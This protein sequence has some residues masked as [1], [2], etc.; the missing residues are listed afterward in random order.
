[1]DKKNRKTDG[2]DTST[3]EN[4]PKVFSILIEALKLETLTIPGRVNVAGLFLLAFIIVMYFLTNSFVSV[5]RVVATFWNGAMTE[6]TEDNILSLLIVFVVSAALCIIML[7][8]THRENKSLYRRE[9][10][11]KNKA[12]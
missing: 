12:D 9:G 11:E 2:K 10:Q 8:R 4:I 7:Y 1:M 5:A 3:R 6:Q